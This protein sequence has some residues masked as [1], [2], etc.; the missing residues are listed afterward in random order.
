MYQRSLFTLLFAAI[1]SSTTCADTFSVTLNVV[2]TNDKPVAKAEAAPFW[3]VKDGKM[4]AAADKGGVTD[5][6]GKTVLTVDNWSKKTAGTG[7]V[8]RSFGRRYRRREQSRRRQRADGEV[9]TDRARDG[10]PG[11]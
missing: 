6:A 4:V 3:N 5:A 2:D 1:G 10:Q 9:V 11:V 8:S 7:L